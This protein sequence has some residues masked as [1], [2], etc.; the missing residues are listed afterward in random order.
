MLGTHGTPLQVLDHCERLFL[1][2]I[3][4]EVVLELD[5]NP[6]AVSGYSVMGTPLA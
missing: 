5:D 6:L 1:G 4:Q 3:G 2:E